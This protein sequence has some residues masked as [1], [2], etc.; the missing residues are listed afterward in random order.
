MPAASR[1]LGLRTLGIAV[2][3][4][5]WTGALPAH[6]QVQHVTLTPQ[7]AELRPLSAD[8]QH[9]LASIREWSANYMRNLPD[10]MCIQTVKRRA[11]AAK[12]DAWPVSDE[13]R[14][15]VVWSNHKE[16][17]EILS[18]NGKPVH[19]DMTRLGGNFSTGEFGTILDRLF[20]PESVAQF[21]YERKA[22]LRGIPVDVLAYRVSSEHGYTLYSGL[23]SYESAWEGLIYAS[24][25]DGTILRIRME[26]IGIP[27]NF[28]VHHLNM[29]LD[30]AAAKIGGHEYILP[31][32]FD[33]TQE[34]SGGVTQNH[35]EY[36][37]YRKFE[38]EAS[39]SPEE[40]KEP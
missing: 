3:A 30:Y 13:V 40:S 8:Q 37:S 36:G 12:L 4:I 27:V 1:F 10:Y 9:I 22:T 15:S 14:E 39:F 20:G 34:S 23:R 33:L 2:M 35:A 24:R 26:C 29:T 16:N 6:A 11:L 5:L 25:K 28:P 17:Y 21:G 7:I 18:V 19:K 32:R 38:T 31:S